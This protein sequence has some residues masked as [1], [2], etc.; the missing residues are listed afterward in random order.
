[1]A[2]EPRKRAH[3]DRDGRIVLPQEVSTHYGLNPGMELPLISDE[4]YILLSRPIHRL[5]KLYIEPTDACNLHCRTCIR[6]SW[7]EPTGMMTKETFAHIIAGI[8]EFSPRPSV[9]FGGFGEPLAH[10]EILQMVRTAK[11]L[12]ASVELIT[13]GTMLDAP[14]ARS[15]IMAGLDRLWVSLDGAR[16]ESYAD[17]RLGARLPQVISNLRRFRRLQGETSAPQAPQ[18]R[19]GIAFVAMRRNIGDLPQLLALAQELG[20]SDFHV[21]HVLPYTKELETEALYRSP[22]ESGYRPGTTRMRLYLPWIGDSSFLP[23][24]ALDDGCDKFHLYLTEM[25]LDNGRN[26]CPF[27]E[28]GSASI[29]WDGGL[30]PCLELLHSHTSYL[31]GA[32]RTTNRY[33]IGNVRDQSLSE[34]WNSPEYVAFRERV[35]DF[36]FAPCAW[37]ASCPLA[38]ENGEDCYGNPAPSCGGC[39]WAQGLIRCP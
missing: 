31:N 1:M 30:S 9:F 33:V 19:L 8:E 6:N 20:V 4:D 27:I 5:A 38:Q 39:L 32:E 29:A 12:G 28:R 2:D 14:T 26:R 7:D 11:Q 18:T 3:V 15:L 21:S 23:G 16:P 10:P 37:C 13:N 17:I 34:L 24:I 36:T 22:A 35:A 25:P